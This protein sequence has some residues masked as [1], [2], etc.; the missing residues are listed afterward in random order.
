MRR[1]AG[2]FAVCGAIALL[3]APGPSAAGD[4]G[5]A[6]SSPQ[7]GPE[8]PAS[9]P[10]E[11]RS[12]FPLLADEALKRGYEL[13]LPYGASLVFTG[14]ANRQIEVTDVRLDVDGVPV[15]PD[16]EFVNLGSSSDVFNANLKF[17]V[18]VLPFL[19]VY[20][21]VG[22][23]YNESETTASVTLPTPGPGGGDVVFDGT[24]KTE[25]D[26]VIGGLG[27]ALA[28]G[29][30]NF[31]L[32]ADCSYIRSDLGFD[33]DFTATIATVRAGYRGSPAGFPMQTWIGVGSWDTAATAIGHSDL[34]GGARFTFEADQRPHTKW[35][36]DVGA[37]FEFTK[38]FQLVTDV[39]FDF[40]GGYLLVVGPTWRFGR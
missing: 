28:G 11:R 34:P 20:A 38:T 4:H 27:F 40:E 32:V 17:D 2:A 15:A 30:G 3:G 29:Y 31:F 16:A 7:S 37:N 26:G 10:A 35:M 9:E 22:Y 1:R 6:A 13:P 14:L 19:N 21:L 36:Y 5:E 23:V 8:A 12:F 25:L 24:V 33:D 39:G 18:F